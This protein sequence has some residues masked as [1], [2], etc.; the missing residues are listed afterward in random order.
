VVLGYALAAAVAIPLGFLIGMSP[1]AYGALNPYIQVLKPISPLAWMPLAL[2]IIRDSEASSVDEPCE[3]PLDDP[4][5]GLDLKR[6]EAGHGDGLGLDAV[7]DAAVLDEGLLEA[8]VG[9][10]LGDAASLACRGVHGDEAA[11]V[12]GHVGGHD[13]HGQQQAQGVDHREEFPAHRLLGGVI[14]F[15]V[16]CADSLG[17]V[18]DWCCPGRRY[19][20]VLRARVI[21]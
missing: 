11:E 6:V 7:M 13:D 15:H 21:A 16:G 1:V 17:D 4:S 20:L 5:A 18:N 2:F 8:A 12:V 10:Y 3:G 19:C 9:P 14:A